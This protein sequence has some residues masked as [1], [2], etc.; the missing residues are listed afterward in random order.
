LK[1]YDGQKC[2]ACQN[3]FAKHDD[4]V[5]CPECGAPHHR[6]C[7]LRAG[8]CAVAYLHGKE[9][10]EPQF[11]APG[12]LESHKH[13]FVCG[14][15]NPTQADFCMKCGNS[16]ERT[17]DSAFSGMS[18]FGT[19]MNLPPQFAGADPHQKIEDVTAEEVASC[20]VV[21]TA[22][23]M[24]R[25]IAMHESKNK[26]S[27][28]MAAFLFP[29][30]WFFYR[31]IY[32]AGI[33]AAAVGVISYVMASVYLPPFYAYWQENSNLPITLDELRQI[34]SPNAKLFF[35][36]VLLIF[37]VNLIM[38]LLANHLYLKEILRKIKKV[39]ASELDKDEYH[40][41]LMSEGGVSFIWPVLV[42]FIIRTL[43]NLFFSMFGG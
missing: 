12:T 18:V 25:F 2:P 31:K 19:S 34:L 32:G 5:V 13:C 10:Y 30:L 36:S 42:F 14:Y 37:I 23:Y 16:L 17:E 15:D 22:Y 41:N 11:A 26:I 8:R 4:I 35:A 33:I 39:K 9:D 7:F 29:T 20:V 28:N 6:A 1:S 24:P 38:G 40:M 27:F 3:A 21:N 43:G